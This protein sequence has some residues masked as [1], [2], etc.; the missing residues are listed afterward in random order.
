MANLNIQN[1]VFA[2]FVFGFAGWFMES[3][4]ES[5]VRKRFV[6][7]G[8]FKGPFVPCQGFGGL[9]VVII[10]YPFKAHPVAVFFGGIIIC[11]VIEYIT[12]IFLEKCFKVKCW[13]YTTYPHTSWCHFQGRICLTISLFFGIIT[14]FILYVFWDLI[15]FVIQNLGNRIWIVDGVMLFL[16]LA[17]IIF[18]CTKI[19]KNNK[20]GIKIK[21]FAVFSKE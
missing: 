6:S 9:G 11:T 8:F 7:K 10:A 16:F 20:A 13:D 15:M 12:A 18:T 19:I 3:I 4:Q 2:F 14:L 17:D 5:I 1:I 21:G